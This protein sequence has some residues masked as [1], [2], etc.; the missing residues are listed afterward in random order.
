MRLLT[1]VVVLAVVAVVPALAMDA[2]GAAQPP[3]TAAGPADVGLEEMMGGTGMP[4]Q[5]ALMMQ[6]LGGGGGQ[7]DPLTMMMLMGAMDGGGMDKDSLGG[8]MFMK[9]LS[10]A[11]AAPVQPVVVLH[12]DTLIIVEGGSVYKVNLATMTVMDTVNYKPQ[13]AQ[14]NPLQSLLPMLM[15][16]HR[17]EIQAVPEAV[18]E[19]PLTL[20]AQPHDGHDH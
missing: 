17:E 3:A 2:V 6:L 14:A 19:A 11:T 12:Q 16:E 9:M 7:M 13:A 10:G 20:E 4:P 1:C 15:M 8:L 5:A 18:M